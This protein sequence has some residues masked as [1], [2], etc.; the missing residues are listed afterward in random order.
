MTRTSAL[1]DSELCSFGEHVARSESAMITITVLGL[2]AS[3][4]AGAE[5]AS[6]RL[7][8]VHKAPGAARP[9]LNAPTL[10]AYV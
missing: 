8:R 5:S 2:R 7:K 1:G 10:L 9:E 6:G 3:S 4:E